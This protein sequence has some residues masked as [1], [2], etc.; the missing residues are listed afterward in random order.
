M[1]GSFHDAEDLVQETFL[2]AWRGIRRFEGRVS[3]RAWLYRIATNACLNAIA[4]RKSVRRLLPEAHG[5]PSQQM[6]GSEPATDIAWL[7][8]YPDSELEGIADT[9]P[10]PDARYEMREAIQL[11]F[12]AAI[13]ALAASPARRSSAARRDGLVRR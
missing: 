1:L 6:P 5:P 8:P 10:G 9:A 12:I 4:S 3:F 11:A 7:E 2:R 13:S